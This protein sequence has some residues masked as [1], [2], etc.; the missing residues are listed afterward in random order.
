MVRGLFQRPS[1]SGGPP[2]EEEG[3]EDERDKLNT[4]EKIKSFEF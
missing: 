1:P 4:D 2:E 3:E